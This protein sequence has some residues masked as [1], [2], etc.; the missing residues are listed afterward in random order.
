MSLFVDKKFINMISSRL[1]L[2]SWKKETLANF[3]CPIC[4][5]SKKN[6]RKTRGYFFAKGND[7]YFR[8]H[9]CGASHTLFKFLEIVCPALIKEYA[10][11][12]WKGGEN[13]NSNYKKPEF[14]FDSPKFKPNNELLQTIDCVESLSADHFCRQF[15]EKRKIPSIHYKNLYF[16]NNFA[17]FAHKIDINVKAPEDKRLVIPIFDSDEQMIGVQGRALDPQAEVRYITIK[18]NKQIER[19][20]YGLDR[21]RDQKIVFVVEG[22][23]DSLFLDN[24]IAMVGI[25]DGSNLPEELADKTVIFALDNE[26]RNPQVIAQMKKIISNGNK[27]VIWDDVDGKDINDMILAGKTKGQLVSIMNRCAVSGA[28]ALLKLNSWR[29]IA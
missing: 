22:P 25:C 17:K 1:D 10:L 3:R 2:F 6:K 7:M 9:N 21:V 4:G 16:T 18:A 19:L 13:G 27:I 14:S 11:E 26:P 29:K 12:R 23:L 5:D 24:A 28:E 15:V 8:C 20:W